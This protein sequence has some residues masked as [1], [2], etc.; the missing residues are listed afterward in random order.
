[1]KENKKMK[2]IRWFADVRLS[3][4]P[5]VGGKNASL[6]QMIGDLQQK[7][8]RIPDGFAITAE[9]YWYHINDNNLLKPMQQL[10]AELHAVQDVAVLQKVGAEIRRLI[11]SAPLPEDMA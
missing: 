5:T 6:G 7:G 8:V 9:G 3:D 11:A 1:M 10:V 4:V 2:Y